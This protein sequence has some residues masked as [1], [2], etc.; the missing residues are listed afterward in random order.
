MNEG[1]LEAQPK[2]SSSV[3]KCEKHG[4]HY[5]SSTMSG[6][7]R[8]RREVSGGT[9]EMR[10]AKEAASGSLGQ[11]LIVTVILLALTTAGLYLT[12]GLLA[13]RFKALMPE[14]AQ[15]TTFEVDDLGIPADAAEPAATYSG[16]EGDGD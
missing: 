14:G 3:V 11:A 12:H 8:C 4:L 5:D 15:E 16:P 2:R 10:T 7:V 6:C 13:K 1:A 9:V